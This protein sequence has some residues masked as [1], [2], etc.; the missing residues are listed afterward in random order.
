DDYEA[1]YPEDE[2]FH[3]ADENARVW[4]VYMEH[5]EVDDAKM[6][7]DMRDALDVLLVFAGLFASV[8][9][10][11]VAQ[12]SQQL[13]PDFAEMTA[14]LL[15]EANAL[16]RALAA[17]MPPDSVPHSPLSP[18]SPFVPNSSIVWV[19][20]LWM[21]SLTLSLSA[22]LLAVIVKQWLRRYME[23]RP[24]GSVRERARVRQFRFLSLWQWH[25]FSLVGGIP[26]IV[27][28]SVALFLAGL[29]I[30]LASL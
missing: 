22:A 25:V 6:T 17:G 11:F 29:T 26:V 1:K 23:N 21:V 10:T 16:Q 7:A 12:T 18:E 19:N 9:T 8:L 15:F 24:T 27:H 30:L 2:P 14:S 28:I 3:E 5:A 20:A 4:H 13:S